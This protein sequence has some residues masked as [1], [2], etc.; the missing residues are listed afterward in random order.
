MTITP[1]LGT[2]GTDTASRSY[3]HR[4]AGSPLS[5]PGCCAFG[6]LVNGSSA[7]GV[8][9]APSGDASLTETAWIDFGANHGTAQGR[10]PLI[11][12][13]SRISTRAF[14]RTSIG[15]SPEGSSP[16]KNDGIPMSRALTSIILAAHGSAL[17][18]T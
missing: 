12:T 9:P 15:F 11:A 2:I 16:P 6:S 1:V 18:G 8:W 5:D 14:A 3:R 17:S 4:I 13:T 7:S 10:K